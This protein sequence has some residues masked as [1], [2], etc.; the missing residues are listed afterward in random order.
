[1]QPTAANVQDG[2]EV[3]VPGGTRELVIVGRPPAM[4]EIAIGAQKGDRVPLFHGA[5]IR[6][7]RTFTSFWVFHFGNQPIQFDVVALGDGEVIDITTVTRTELQWGWGRLT[8]R[9]ASVGPNF[10][11]VRIANTEPSVGGKA[12]RIKR[13]EV[14]LLTNPANVR[15]RLAGTNVWGAALG[16]SVITTQAYEEGVNNLLT[17]QGPKAQIEALDVAAVPAPS[18][19][20]C[21]YAECNTPGDARGV[22][23]P[24]WYLRSDRRLEL[25]ALDAG[26]FDVAVTVWFD[27]LSVDTPIG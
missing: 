19:S 1:M 11:R 18:T 17:E 6:T 4:S 13:V 26:A 15:F 16:G 24:D 12:I 8:S 5:R 20:Q 25:V 23:H 27:P 9:Y 14:M 22:L 10:W 2:L 21:M 3:T 7:S